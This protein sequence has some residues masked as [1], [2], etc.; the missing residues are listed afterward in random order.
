VSTLAYAVLIPV[1]ASGLGPVTEVVVGVVGVALVLFLWARLWSTPPKGG[2][3]ISLR[4]LEDASGAD[5]S[6]RRLDDADARA[7]GDTIDDEVIR[8]NGWPPRSVRQVRRM[9]SYP[10]VAAESGQLVICDD[11]GRLVGGLSLTKA[12]AGDGTAQLGCWIGP[13]D[14]GR[15]HGALAIAAAA[16]LARRSGIREL[17]MGTA[18]TNVAMIRSFEKAGAACVES[19]PHRLPD[20]TVVDSLWF[21]LATS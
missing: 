6:L 19:R 21:V 12:D 18:R 8:A 14:R 20:G 5:V 15:G 17:R 10:L 4:D 13:R 3:A 9:A 16:G 1:L 7:Y 2:L 11:H